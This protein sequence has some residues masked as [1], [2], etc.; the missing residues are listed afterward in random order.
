MTKMYE[1][2]Q[3]RL[4][5]FEN[6]YIIQE[7]KGVNRTTVIPAFRLLIWSIPFL[8]DDI[9]DRARSRGPIVVLTLGAHLSMTSFQ[10]KAHS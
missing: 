10:R 7:E 6:I 9:L 1:F 3:M 2:D 8:N 4:R 5:S